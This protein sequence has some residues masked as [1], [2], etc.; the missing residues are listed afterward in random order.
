VLALAVSGTSLYVG[1]S[2][3]LAGGVANTSRVAKWSGSAWIP[4]G[5]GAS[6][7]VR[8]LAVVGSDLYAG[9]DFTT[10]GG[11]TVNRVAKW[12]GSAWSALGTGAN[13]AV[14]A[15]SLIG[16][17]VYAGGAFTTVGGVAVS[18]V[19][20]WNGS[21]WSALG[22]GTNGVVNALAMLGSDLY[23]GGAF[24]TAGGVTVNCVAKWNGSA[25]SALGDGVNYDVGVLAFG[26]AEPAVAPARTSDA[27]ATYA[28]RAPETALFMGGDFTAAGDGTPATYFTY[29]TDSAVLPVEL[30][31]F[32][33]TASG[34]TA[35]LSWT[36]A[37]ET[38]NTG[39]V[40]ERQTGDA[41][42]DVSALIAGQGTTTERA[43]YAYDVAGLT[44]G[45]HT[46]RL[47][48]TDT[49]GTLHHSASVTIEIGTDG[50]TVVTILGNGSAS[51]RVRI[52]GSGAVRAEVYDVLGRS[53]ARVYDGL[54]SGTAEAS[55]P[56]LSSGSYVVR[57]TS[58]GHATIHAVVVR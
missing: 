27:S 52:E 36:T 2:F 30:V 38:N 55:L 1:G 8:A 23:A 33:G 22:G 46:F 49:D 20:K 7:A 40:V 54:V 24:T 41:W 32:S 17:D 21:A 4:L 58:D 25:W 28:V 29:F 43:D 44:A 19:A 12:N 15:L 5:V 35:H 50:Q 57:V 42:T 47:R 11:V 13:G 37:S 39:F 14:N 51:P 9:G 16:S 53:V 18:Y 56:S 48:Q 10:A 45:R 6:G 26:L 31:S 3:T 34:R